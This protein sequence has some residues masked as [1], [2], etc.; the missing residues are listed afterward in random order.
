M[1]VND[2]LV[3]MDQKG[4]IL[5]IAPTPFFSD[6]GCHIRIEGI[7]RCLTELGH[8]NHVCTYHHGRDM[9]TVE[10]SR[11]SPIKH[12]TQTAAGPSRYKPWADW[13]LLWLV[14]ARFYSLKPVAI[15]AHLHEGLLIG[16]IVKWLFFWRGTPLVADMQGSLSGELEAHGS[17]KKLGFLRLPTRIFERLLLWGADYIVCSSQHSLDK[18]AS[19]FSVPE[20]KIS[21]VQDGADPVGELNETRRQELISQY[22]LPTDKS[23]VVYSGALLESKG[24]SAL[25]DV[26]AA[27]SSHA[28][29]LHFLII[30]YPKDQLEVFL[31][32][33][34]LS[35]MAT[36]VGQVPFA[37]LA[38]YL[39]LAAVAI[40]PKNSDAGEGSGKMLNYLACGLPVVAFDTRNNREFLPD[41][42]PLA[43]NSTDFAELLTVLIKNDDKREQAADVNL[44]KFQESYSWNQSAK[45]LDKVYTRLLA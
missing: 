7:V 12:Y 2:E 19:E 21:L 3:E 5:H 43:S 33:Q 18:M 40:D 4:L 39:G 26:I 45:Q 44:A 29:Q 16:L 37:D 9:D 27:S 14:V 22:E 25:K 20:N 8:Q 31:H 28:E 23:L 10:C 30:G 6:R 11:I 38:D 34:N 17:F 1:Q 15:H 35:G 36:L 32:E 42:T 13:K 24:L 41:D